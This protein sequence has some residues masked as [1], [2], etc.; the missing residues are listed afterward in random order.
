MTGEVKMG[1]GLA[2]VDQMFCLA[3]RIWPL[4]VAGN[5]CF[6]TRSAVRPSHVVKKPA[7]IALIQVDGTRLNATLC[8]YV[9]MSRFLFNLYTLLTTEV[10]VGS[11]GSACGEISIVHM[12][13]ERSRLPGSDMFVS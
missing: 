10:G 5:F 11:C 13:F 12:P 3:E 6:L 7:F 9:I 1:V 8:K 2:F 4:V